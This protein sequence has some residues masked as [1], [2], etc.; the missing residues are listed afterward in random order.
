[1]SCESTQRLAAAHFG[2]EIAPAISLSADAARDVLLE[3]LNLAQA[4]AAQRVIPGESDQTAAGKLLRLQ[5][6]AGDAAARE[7][8]ISCFQAMAAMNPPLPPPAHGEMDPALGFALPKRASQHAWRAVWETVQAAHA[9]GPLPN[10]AQEV[11][12]ARQAYDTPHALPPLLPNAPA[13]SGVAGF[14]GDLR[15]TGMGT[16]LA[17]FFG[18]SLAAEEALG[19]LFATA[20]RQALPRAITAQ[21]Q[22][23]VVRQ[24]LQEAQDLCAWLRQ[25][26]ITPPEIPTG[27]DDNAARTRQA[28]ATVRKVITTIARDGAIT[29]NTAL[30]SLVAAAVPHNTLDSWGQQR[31]SDLRT[32]AQ[33][34]DRSPLARAEGM[35]GLARWLRP[36]DERR[37]LLLEGLGYAQKVQQPRLAAVMQQFAEATPG[38][39]LLRSALDLAL[40]ARSADRRHT[41]LQALSG[42]CDAASLT[43]LEQRSAHMTDIEQTVRQIAADQRDALRQRQA[44]TCQDCGLFT[45]HDD[46]HMCSGPSLARARARA[47]AEQASR[48]LDSGIPSNRRQALLE[49]VRTRMDAILASLTPDSAD[50]ALIR[51]DRDSLAGQMARSE[52]YP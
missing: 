1:M 48:L 43:W 15:I 32:G 26:G 52:E 10:L 11:C 22:A 6:Q 42:Y 13:P 25:L 47:I 49:I 3:V 14:A 17:R 29:A 18:S 44:R 51:A 45:G 24:T 31:L 46:T 12:L 27:D 19:Q 50:A 28:Y 40:R 39:D 36:N 16:P 9:G 41:M 34:W 21:T 8:T 33:K 7:A 20:R 38:P 5:A 37:A 23:E 2:A 4:R 30:H 35:I